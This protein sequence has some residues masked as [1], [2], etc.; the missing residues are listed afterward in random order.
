MSSVFHCALVFFAIGAT[1]G[2]LQQNRST[3]LEVVCVGK[4]LFEYQNSLINCT[5]NDGVDNCNQLGLYPRNR[6]KCDDCC[7]TSLD[8]VNKNQSSK[9][10]S[11]NGSTSTIL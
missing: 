7:R 8:D 9:Y 3:F 1:T 4:H 6:K 2:I 11:L 5:D 10:E